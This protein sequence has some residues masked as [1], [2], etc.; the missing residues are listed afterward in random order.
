MAVRRQRAGRSQRKLEKT[1]WG[2][3]SPL[4]S[5]W[6]PPRGAKGP[7]VILP[8]DDVLPTGGVVRTAPEKAARYDDEDISIATAIARGLAMAT[9]LGDD[10]IIGG[11]APAGRILSI[12]R[13]GQP[14]SYAIGWHPTKRGWSRGQEP[15]Q[16]TARWTTMT[17]TS[18]SPRPSNVA[19]Q[20]QQLSATTASWA[21]KGVLT[22][23][24]TVRPESQG[25]PAA[26]GHER[27]VNGT[28][29][30]KATGGTAVARTRSVV[31]GFRDFR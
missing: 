1:A 26:R 7:A 23:A 15:Q 6:G 2:R 25:G 18:T 16:R 29:Q 9:V 14:P 19:L 3:I 17:R 27:E 28:P 22:A 11:P 20:K 8:V 21:T 31:A 5:Q 12:G 10:I 13:P 4:E 30:K 24:P